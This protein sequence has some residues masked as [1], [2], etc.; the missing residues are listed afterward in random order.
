LIV[1]IKEKREGYLSEGLNKMKDQNKTKKQLID[2]L[3][4]L[5]Q[6]IAELEESEIDN[7]QA[8]QELKRIEWL[9]SNAVQRKQKD[10]V[11][12]YG[13]LVK[14]NTCRLI[15]DS[16]GE[17]VLREIISDYLELLDTS[18]A[19][20]EKNG[21]YALGIFSSNWCRVLDQASRNLCRTDNNREALDCGKWHCHESCW[22]EASKVSI[23]TG[24]PVDIEC[25]GGIRLF[26][27]PIWV[28]GEIVGSINFGYG[29]PP[30][31]PEKLYEIAERYG[32]GMDELL[33]C[34]REYESRPP[35]IIDVAKNRLLTSARLIGEI[36]ER[37]RAEE[38][39]RK[40]THELGERVKALNCLY[41]FSSLIERPDI[42]LPEIFQ[43][44]VD[45]IP[46][47]WQYPEA[48]CA[49]LIF[50]DEIYKT[51]NFTETLWKQS[52]P[53]LVDGERKGT[54]EVYHLEE[55]PECEEG[56]FLKEERDLLNALAGRLGKTIQ[57]RR[58]EEEL[59]LRNKIEKV[60]LNVPDDDMYGEVL[61]II[62]EAMESKYGI[63]G[64]IDEHGTL[65]IPSMT[66]DI[67]EQ[68]QL[69]DKTIEFS[70]ETWGGIWGRGLIEKRSLYANE[71]LRVP[72]G[73][74]P[75]IRIL[76]TPIMYHGEVIGLLEVGN[77][78]TDYKEKDKDF[79]ERIAGYIAPILHARL[80]RDFHERGRRQAEESLRR[81]HEELGIR[82][83]QRTAE[84]QESENRLRLLSSQLLTIQEKE[85]KRVAQE[86]HDGI[87]QMLTA[88]KFRVENTLQQERE[89][90]IEAKE[91]SIESII[92]MIQD[93]VEEVR[94]IQMDLRPSILDDVGILAT[95]GWF[96][97]E[98]QKVYSAIHIEKEIEI[99]E[100]EVSVPLKTVI[101]RV[102]QEAMN[103]IAKH[104]QA[105][106]VRLSLKK[107]GNRI[108]FVIED[109]GIGFDLEKSKRGFGLGSMKE[110]TEL[111]G[112]T[113][114]VESIK[115]RG[116]V[117]HASWPI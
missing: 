68:C 41:A 33:K 46:S 86:L 87:G 47:G 2:E 96:C 91:E 113:F 95:I 49:R 4:E 3:M 62:L 73:H 27:V 89:R 85:R 44:T 50:E 40:K 105:D 71:G 17:E 45:I 66:R 107:M 102:M 1:E 78:A 30:R 39:L 24:Q 34:A 55:K 83:Q 110:R 116:T 22:R 36:I 117:I 76:V 26:A 94:R 7:N 21:D 29:D 74:I 56:P 23:E 19:V 75:T 69:P 100:D 52:S 97:R 70:R 13:S 32:I 77:K 90:K 8:A 15:L 14:V 60:F 67:W 25:K 61:Q 11:P 38:A 112:G 18:G 43:G 111:S 42:S 84:L 98:F 28:G 115:G 104:S 114:T 10:Y 12:P 109:N 65:I 106:V 57:R 35:F 48:T 5:R 53:I 79:L 64:Y 6:R 88:I 37:K 20:Y 81:S 51:G 59:S 9:L 72:K 31:D 16:A 103:N 93:S 82:V 63:F 99:Q 54:L 58:A 80:Q 92:Q 108:E 101:Y